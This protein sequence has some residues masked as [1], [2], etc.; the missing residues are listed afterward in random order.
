MLLLLVKKGEREKRR[1]EYKIREG[2]T[3]YKSMCA[4]NILDGAQKLVTS[5]RVWEIGIGGENYFLPYIILYFFTLF[6]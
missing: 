5:P 2:Q 4:Q 6:Y 3:E 1:G